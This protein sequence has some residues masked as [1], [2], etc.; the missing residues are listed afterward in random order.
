MTGENIFST[1]FSASGIVVIGNESNGI[2]E[3]TE[4][5]ITN[6]ITIPSW[7]AQNDLND[8]PESLNA[9]IAMAIVCSEIRR[10]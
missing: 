5:M 1:K 9:A 7:K 4:Q 8:R 2:R 3:E 6:R 10:N